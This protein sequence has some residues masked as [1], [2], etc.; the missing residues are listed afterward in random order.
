MPENVIFLDID[1]V[2][3]P[4]PDPSRYGDMDPAC[5]QVLNAI[6]EQSG[7]AIV[8]TSSMRYGKSNEQLQELLEEFGFVGK[9][10][11]KTPTE[12]RGLTRG[13][14]ITIWLAEN[15]VTGYVILDDHAD[16]GVHI[17]QLVQTRP[18]KGLLDQHIAHAIEALARP[19][20]A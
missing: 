19:V 1:G 16:V 11:G 6:V 5:V 12:P 10:I 9:V 2:L 20:P 3:A 13:E 18:S 17:G 4:I 7:A 8:V 14:E 15:P